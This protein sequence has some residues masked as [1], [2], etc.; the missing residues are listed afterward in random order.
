MD[1]HADFLIIIAVLAVGGKL[2]GQ[3]GRH[4]GLPTAVGKITL[5]LIIGPAM[6]GIV[7]NEGA[8]IDLASI[9]VIILMFL[10]GLETDTETMR[11]VTVPAFA[12][13][14][15][16]VVFPFLGGLA[17]GAVF[18]LGTSETLF[19]GAILT[20]TSVSIS[21]Q[22][23][24]ELGHLRSRA[25]T[26]ILAAAVIDDILGI[27]VLAFV[28][29]STG[30]DPLI[31]IGK[32]AAFL[33]LALVLGQR[34]LAPLASR[35]LP[36]LPEEA[37]LAVL[38]GGA[39]SYSWAAEHLGGVAAVT[40]AY[41]AGL[42]ASQ[43]EM[44]HSASRGLN[45]MAYGF[46]VPISFVAIGLQADFVSLGEAPLLVL[47]LLAVAV[48]AKVGGCF[49]GARVT[50][51]SGPDSV[52]VGVGMMS[53]GEVAL[54]IAAAGLEAGIVER[55]VFSAAILMTLVTTVL[56]PIVLK[57]TYRQGVESM[58][59]ATATQTEAAPSLL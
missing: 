1:A 20:A 43:T 6:L 19:L 40:G 5:G 23:L 58:D 4:I 52:R 44:G 54:V 22:T 3:V 9:G 8:V 12:V 18:Q 7:H 51:F 14:I 28:F 57:L 24:R 11:R 10:A 33:P 38:L 48:I 37:Q 36:R 56:T 32:M 41:M 30:G 47:A 17:I 27:I 29:A 59:G 2:A 26:T 53:R 13:A 42:I 49:A 45:W 16:G 25:G 34:V 15:G 50:G 21:A 39:L 31:S 35:A 55:P 46:F